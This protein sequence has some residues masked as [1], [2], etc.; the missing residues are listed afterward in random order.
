M[1]QTAEDSFNLALKHLERVSVSSYDPA[2]W[3]DLSTFGFYCLEACIVAAALHLQRPRPGSHPRKVEEAQYLALENGLP[4]VGDLLVDL[5]N[6]RK[7]EAYGDA[8]PP[9]GLDPED[10]AS[11]IEEYVGIVRSLLAR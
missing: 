9:D 4:D 11:E 7:Y 5:N 1:S 3:L 6:M 10:V 2:N 8:D